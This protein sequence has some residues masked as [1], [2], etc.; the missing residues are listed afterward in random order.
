M[1]P[2]TYEASLEDEDVLDCSFCHRSMFRADVADCEHCARR[3]RIADFAFQPD[4]FYQDSRMPTSLIVAFLLGVVAA[5][6][7]VFG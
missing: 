4:D 5:V 1:T 7:V 6:V 2:Y 3:K